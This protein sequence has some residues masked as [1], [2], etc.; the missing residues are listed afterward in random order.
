MEVV[1]TRIGIK[2]IFKNN[3][4]LTR[5]SDPSL[6][7]AAARPAWTSTTVVGIYP[8]MRTTTSEVIREWSSLLRSRANALDACLANALSE[9]IH[10]RSVFKGIFIQRNLC[11]PTIL[12]ILK[13]WKP[14]G[15]SR[16]L[17]KS[18]KSGYIMESHWSS[19]RLFYFYILYCKM[20]GF[21]LP[22]WLGW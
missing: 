9:Y 5:P 3:R 22:P 19:G 6:G 20:L 1:R 17:E 8:L 16:I 15:I 12:E 7:W 10:L 21:F 11:S 2:L 13:T 4:S 18:W 14:H